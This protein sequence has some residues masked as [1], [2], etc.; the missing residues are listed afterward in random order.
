MCIDVGVSVGSSEET[1]KGP[2]RERKGALRGLAVEGSKTHAIL[3]W[4]GRT[5]DGCVW[6]WQGQKDEAEKQGRDLPKL[7]MCEALIRKSVPL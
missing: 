3:G 5:L 2:M 1:E 7:R 4:K 6:G